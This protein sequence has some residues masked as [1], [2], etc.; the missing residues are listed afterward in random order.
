MGRKN[1]LNENTFKFIRHVSTET[2]L[3]YKALRVEF[4]SKKKC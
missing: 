1:V 3:M 4:I 2:L